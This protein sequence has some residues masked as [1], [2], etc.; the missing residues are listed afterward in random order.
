MGL[1]PPPVRVD[2]VREE[3]PWQLWVTFDRA[4]MFF[5]MN[6]QGTFG[7]QDVFVGSHSVVL[8]LKAGSYGYFG[9][10]R[11]GATGL[12]HSRDA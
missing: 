5:V 4:E 12:D 1:P 3:T 11:S 6:R 7:G 8:F 10:E 2:V 9:V